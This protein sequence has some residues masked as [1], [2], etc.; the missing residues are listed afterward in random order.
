MPAG[1][2]GG[3]DAMS[4]LGCC[5]LLEGLPR[6]PALGQDGRSNGVIEVHP[7]TNVA[8]ERGG[9]GRGPSAVSREDDEGLQGDEQRFP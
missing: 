4:R 3:W 6:D 1:G 2:A 7:L 8:E 5:W 9:A